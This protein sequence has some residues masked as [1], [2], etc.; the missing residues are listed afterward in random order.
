[1]IGAAT[2]C[3]ALCYRAR[4]RLRGRESRIRTAHL[5][6]LSEGHHRHIAGVFIGDP[7]RITWTTEGRVDSASDRWFPR[8]PPAGLCRAWCLLLIN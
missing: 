1:M 7:P 3:R 2:S 6:R 4:H 5:W 8:D